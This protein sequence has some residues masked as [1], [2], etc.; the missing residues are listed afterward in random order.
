MAAKRTP[1]GS[2]QVQDI[3]VTAEAV[4]FVRQSLPQ[5]LRVSED[6]CDAQIGQLKT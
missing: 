5:P 3:Y 2:H 1:A 4:P 6:F